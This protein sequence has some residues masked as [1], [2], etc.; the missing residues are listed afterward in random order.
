MRLRHPSV[1]HRL[2][3]PLRLFGQRVMLRPLTAQDFP[4]WTAVR[5]A[6]E[7]WLVPWEPRRPPSQLDPTLNRDAFVAR[8]AARD[9]DAAAGLAFGFG[10]FVADGLAGEI[11]LNSV[12]RGAMQSATVGY[13]IDQARAGHGY[14]AEGVVAVAQFAFEELE[15]H[16]LEIC[17]VPRNHNSR[18]VMEKLAIREEGLAQRFLEING[19]WEDHVRYGFTVEEWTARRDE[20][21]QRWL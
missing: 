21:R 10:L 13:W 7:Q 5:R 19:I 18:R 3:H 1:G 15:L 20:L 8:C 17:I 11:N 4:T 14:V 9:R 6:N 12:Q 16:R 2:P